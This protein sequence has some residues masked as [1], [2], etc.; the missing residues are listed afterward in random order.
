MKHR[1]F[2]LLLAAERQISMLLIDS[3]ESVPVSVNFYLL[4]HEHCMSYRMCSVYVR[5]LLQPVL[6]MRGCQH[7]VMRQRHRRVQLQN[8]VGGQHVQQ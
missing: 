7:R 1:C 4:L 3:K 2:S 6:H 8:R 5:P